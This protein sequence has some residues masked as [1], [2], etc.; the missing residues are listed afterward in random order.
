MKRKLLLLA[1]V[2]SLSFAVSSGR[3]AQLYI[4]CDSCT[5]ASS[6]IPCKCA[7]NSLHPGAI[8]NCASWISYCWNGFPP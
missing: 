8:S 6:S 5:T 4:L 7:S 1:G 3:A 2:L